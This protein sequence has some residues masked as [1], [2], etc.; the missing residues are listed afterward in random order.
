[1]KNYS[2]IK[3]SIYILCFLMSF[4]SFTQTKEANMGGK[5]EIKI[6]AFDLVFLTTLDMSYERI[7]NSGMS[8][9]ISA[10][11]NFKDNDGY[12]EKFAIT[13][14]FRLYFFNKQDYGAKGFFAEL[15]SKIASGNNWELFS[16]QEEKEYFDVALGFS[17]GK[18][19]I[20]KS[21][22]TF[23]LSLGGGRNLGLD[24][25]SPDLT[26]RGGFS[27]GYRF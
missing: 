11:I 19:W 14:F 27:F 13:P 18:K 16:G 20:N 3:K 5:N 15:F 10:L 22:F 12:Y 23:E 6:D 26:F 17:I 8:Y 9:G 25:N 21:G 7:H 2:K 1:M 24:K 4:Q